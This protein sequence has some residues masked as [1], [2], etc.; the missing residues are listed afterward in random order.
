MD[1]QPAAEPPASST[2]HPKPSAGS[3]THPEP[4]ATPTPGHL[5]PPTSSTASQAPASPEHA[6][7]QSP[8][9]EDQPAPAAD[10]GGPLVSPERELEEFLIRQW[11]EAN[12]KNH[13]YQRIRPGDIMRVSLA[14]VHDSVSASRHPGKK[15]PDSS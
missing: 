10:I 1:P 11:I 7:E 13:S 15:P 6:P 9:T 2:T 8:P 3:T 5:E 4:S 12:K 14:S